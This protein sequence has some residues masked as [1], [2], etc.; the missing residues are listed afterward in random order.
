MTAA[1]AITT[2]ATATATRI[3]TICCGLN[4][5]GQKTHTLA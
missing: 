3:T 2:A 5:L 4:M 1:A